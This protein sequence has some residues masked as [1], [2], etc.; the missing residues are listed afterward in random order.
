MPRL[1]LQSIRKLWKRLDQKIRAHYHFDGSDADGSGHE[2]GAA[3]KCGKDAAIGL[4]DDC[5]E[6]MKL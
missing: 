1:I 2:E 4:I 6:D 5:H 3:R